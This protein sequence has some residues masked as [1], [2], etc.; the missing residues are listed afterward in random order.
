MEKVREGKNIYIESRAILTETN[1]HSLILKDPR[2]DNR[3]GRYIIDLENLSLGDSSIDLFMTLYEPAIR[4]SEEDRECYCDLYYH[5]YCEEK[6]IEYRKQDS[7]AFFDKVRGA[8]MRIVSGSELI[9]LLKKN[10]FQ[11]SGKRER[12]LFFAHRMGIST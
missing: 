9:A 4:L 6:G 2:Q 10:Q 12:A 11:D 8:A 5:Y 7:K 1:N 3:I